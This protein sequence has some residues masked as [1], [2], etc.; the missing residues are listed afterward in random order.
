MD[1][2]GV[3]I[4][5]KIILLMIL[6]L[7]LSNVVYGY[8]QA[9]FNTTEIV[10]KSGSGQQEVVS[11]SVVK[12][13]SWQQTDLPILWKTHVNG[14]IKISF[15][16][17]VSAFGQSFGTW[18]NISYTA[19][20][21]LYAGNTTHT[22]G[23]DN[24][25]VFVFD[26]DGSLLSQGNSIIA[27]TQFFIS[28]STGRLLDADIIFNA[29]DFTFSLTGENDTIDLEA[30]A[31]HEIGH[32][33]GL[34]HA[35]TG[36]EV[37]K[38]VRPTMTPFY[39]G[40]DARTLEQDDR[41]GIGAI[42]PSSSFFLVTGNISGNIRTSL[43]EIF[44]AK[45]VALN[46]STNLPAV[47][48]LSGYHTGKGN[49][50][51]GDFL[52]LGLEPGTYTLKATPMD[53]TNGI[54]SNNF[55]GIFSYQ[56]MTNFRTQYAYNVFSQSQS[57]NITIA[58]NT[59][60]V[61]SFV[62]VIGSVNIP[63]SLYQVITT[64]ETALYTIY[65]SN[66]GNDKDNLSIRVNAPQGAQVALN[67]T[68]FFNVQEGGTRAVLLTLQSST[69]GEYKTSL[70]V[71][72]S[73]NSSA[74]ASFVIT[75]T[76]IPPVIV[77]LV[78]PKHNAF[79]SLPIIDFVCNVTGFNLTQMTFYHNQTGY[80]MSNETV[81]LTGNTAQKNFLVAL[82]DG[83]YSWNCKGTNV[84]AN[85]AF[86]PVNFSVVVDTKK[87]S[88]TFSLN[89]T[90]IE[91]N[92]DTLKIMWAVNDT[93]L[94]E[95][96]L[97][98][99]N[100]D[101][102]LLQQSSNATGVLLIGPL[103]KIGVYTLDIIAQD[104]AGNINLHHSQF[105]VID[106]TSP[107]VALLSPS[108]NSITADKTLVFSCNA[109]D[110][111][112]LQ[113]IALFHNGTDI[114]TKVNISLVSGKTNETTFSVK[115]EEGTL[116][117]NCGATD[118]NGHIAFAEKNFTLIVDRSAPLVHTIELNDTYVNS[119]S[120]L[121]TVN[122]TDTRTNVKESTVNGRPLEKGLLF[123]GIILVGNV[124]GA[125]T[126]T[127]FTTDNANNTV[128][129]YSSYV[130][131][132]SPPQI[133]TTFSENTTITSPKGDAFFSWEVTDENLSKSWLI[134]NTKQE[135]SVKIDKN[136]KTQNLSVLLTNLRAGKHTLLIMA[137]DN[138]SN[139][140][141]VKLS[142]SISR[143]EN[144]TELEDLLRTG[145]HGKIK[146][147]TI[148]DAHG[149][150]LNESFS[151]NQTI[152]KEIIVN[153]S[154]SGVNI[155]IGITAFGEHFDEN[156]ASSV[157][158]EANPKSTVATQVSSQIRGGNLITFVLFQ[159]MSQ[160]IPENKYSFENGT[161]IYTTITFLR[162]LQNLIPFYIA[163]DTGKEVHLLS[164]C[165][166]NASPREEPSLLTMCY[167]NS[168]S[169]VILYVPHL[170]GGGLQDPSAAPVIKLTSPKDIVS[171]SYFIGNGTVFDLNLDTQSC[172]FNLTTTTTLVSSTTFSPVL[173]DVG[174]YTFSISNSGFT[175][176][177]N[178]TTYVLQ[179]SCA[180][181]D[182]NRSTITHHFV[183]NDITPPIVTFSMTDDTSST[184]TGT[185]LITYQT[186][187]RT[188]CGFN[189]STK[190]ITSFIETDTNL[191]T[192]DGHLHIFSQS[193]AA[194]G[195]VDVPTVICIDRTGNSF[196][197]AGF[198]TP[199]SV[200]EPIKS[201]AGSGASG[202]RSGGGG[203]G[204]AVVNSPA[205][206]TK[207]ATNLTE[208]RTVVLSTISK[209]ISITRLI[210]TAKRFIPFLNITIR[211]LA[212]ESG[213]PSLPVQLYG[214]VRIKAFPVDAFQDIIA[215][216]Y[217]AREWIKENKVENITLY[218]LVED[219]WKALSTKKTGES[220][221]QVTYT[222]ALP[223][224]GLFAIGGGSNTK[225]HES[226]KTV[227]SLKERTVTGTS[228]ETIPSQSKESMLQTQS[229][230][231]LNSKWLYLAGFLL[232]ILFGLWLYDAT[233]T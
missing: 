65:I 169:S 19:L 74:Y 49:A 150:P 157:Q 196:R 85:T 158:V 151:L 64:E 146:Q 54:T 78:S 152:L 44:G 162:P 7:L 139:H 30:V 173:F 27:T 12:P 166:G 216:F 203:K 98:V 105:S 79:V 51:Q 102:S 225:V 185:L 145:N 192:T 201:I 119:G 26:E 231:Y 144:T 15:P 35:I 14:S 143:Q 164:Q 38:T 36:T 18:E 11:V 205:S 156:Q 159:N 174:N 97:S 17:V 32:L 31:I 24:E 37:D 91:E 88:V 195:V 142:F 131:D 136:M 61:L 138:A 5:K 111:S 99:S 122:T 66:T 135:Q 170:S 20:R 69:P 172:Y 124:S 147:V 167:T 39:L 90:S 228:N 168:S 155:S 127:L 63:S 112:G 45:I 89:T 82:E 80:F 126:I 153:E 206:L 190:N 121:I 1:D 2:V 58:P 83:A 229:P 34:D 57:K 227:P 212:E 134:V 211:Q 94:K 120:I 191:S 93:Y 193:Y 29:K 181:L 62:G 117:W 3:P 103:E 8:V 114:F 22:I 223:D 178:G 202:A 207:I 75:T 132:V 233:R 101:G 21:F 100:P 226:S 219:R 53:G 163:D 140:A 180:S 46:A 160:Y 129:N 70:N 77:T 222:S 171:N 165:A 81:L 125:Y 148:Y 76:V 176:L 189:S 48:V 68:V 186:D 116:L 118:S 33:F 104:Y 123:S 209:E 224:F 141:S 204:T 177:S 149:Q 213:I 9:T 188:T 72:S 60:T 10:I 217:V 92:Q 106:G 67:Q 110:K 108:H 175:D 221:I 113:E 184:S 200:K 16:E 6:I 96:M 59:Q 137:E 56:F 13:V 130:V 4:M 47:A 42:Y 218:Q 198:L 50:G 220:E 128:T 107:S 182:S 86:A 183:V 214:Y 215:D 84:Y 232:V 40:S 95:V 154:F 43:G 194:S 115:A 71:S 23:Y 230:E 41:A 208:G 73:A 210:A 179:V 197:T 28:L 87:P 109:T 133:T 52:L 25:N 55:N 187:E 199:V 161:K